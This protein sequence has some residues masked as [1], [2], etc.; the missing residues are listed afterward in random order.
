MQDRAGIGR[1]SID[2][3]CRTWGLKDI[4]RA[5]LYMLQTGAFMH[6]KLDADTRSMQARSTLFSGCGLAA[7]DVA[8]SPVLIELVL[9]GGHLAEA[10]L[11]PSFA[12]KVDVAND[13][14][15]LCEGAM[16]GRTPLMSVCA[17]A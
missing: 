3:M 10:P 17:R 16:E 15:A 9:L 1:E 12:A 4:K 5:W 14:H 8:L 13:A 7:T 2:Q 11:D 6:E